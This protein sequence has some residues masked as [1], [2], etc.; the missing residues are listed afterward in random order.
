MLVNFQ[1]LLDVPPYRLSGTVVGALLN[2]PGELAALGSAVHQ[3]P[4]KAP[5]TAP[6]LTV[7]PRNTLCGPGSCRF[8][9]KW[10]PPFSNAA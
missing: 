5:P 10:K 1:P 4:Y 8:A 2:H 3:P 7:R 6:V 9:A